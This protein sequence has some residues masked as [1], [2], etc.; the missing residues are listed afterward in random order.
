MK[1]VMVKR[2]ARYLG[3]RENALDFEKVR[4]PRAER[5]RRWSLRS[6]LTATFVSMVAMEKS[7]RGAERLTRDLSGCRKRFGI[8]RRVP[9]STLAAFFTRLRDEAGLRQV[10][11]DDIKQ[12]RQRKAL[13]PT[14]LPISA[15]AIDG[16]TIWCGKHAVKDPAC[17]AM[18]QEEQ[19]YYRLH[20]LHVVLTSV[21][22]Q[23]CIDQLLVPKETN[24]MGALPQLLNQLVEAYGKSFIE[25]VTLDAGMTSSDNAR[26]IT[27]SEMRYVMAVKETQPTLL[28]EIERLCGWG[29][30]K[31]AGH[32]CDARTPWEVYRGAR[33]R[34]ELY[35]SK[36]I[37]GWRGWESAHQV[38]RVKQTTKHRD[39]RV[40]YENR[41]F[42]TSLPWDR[43]SGQEILRLVR[44]H[45]GVE[46]GCHWTMDVVLGEDTRAWC[47]KGRALRMLSWLR[48][49]AYN[50][51]R[52]LRDRYLRSPGS[53]NMAWD[54]LRRRITRALTTATA[55]GREL[56]SGA[57]GKAV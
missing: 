55:W 20:A 57:V 3:K 28:R 51:L 14:E 15:A 54:E 37:R 43:L 12:A 13:E 53:R 48:L 26:A 46:N 35:R 4:D 1:A 36:S 30:H 34:R 33:I 42:V 17:Q 44:L 38:W 25:V 11:V 39:G 23:P 8:P 5:G 56:S 45:W 22:T 32:I 16:K 7:F 27:A 19:S 31:Q 21:A 40:E 50:A 10:L 18:P 6:L 2:I 24:E 49:L 47:T 9:D 52:F 29:G 41:Y